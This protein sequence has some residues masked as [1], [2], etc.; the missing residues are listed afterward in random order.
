[1]HE[2]NF[3]RMGILLVLAGLSLVYGWYMPNQGALMAARYSWAV[4]PHLWKRAAGVNVLLVVGLYLEYVEVGKP[5]EGKLLL[6]IF[7][8]VN[9]PMMAGAYLQIWLFRKKYRLWSR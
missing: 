6:A 8:L 9:I 1:M 2:S 4:L 5:I 3:F 7:L